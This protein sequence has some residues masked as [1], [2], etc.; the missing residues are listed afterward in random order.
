MKEL[1]IILLL[2]L[3]IYLSFI[4]TKP[5]HHKK[6]HKKHHIPKHAVMP[7]CW[8]DKV[9]P[10]H[11]NDTNNTNTEKYSEFNIQPQ[12]GLIDNSVEGITTSDQYNKIQKIKS[13]SEQNLKD[14][15]SVKGQL[16]NVDDKISNLNNQIT[17]LRLIR[18][19]QVENLEKLKQ[20]YNS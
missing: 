18:A 15:N 6:H 7:H 20:Y 11:F 17:D 16:K 9:N 1:I 14:I 4:N 10:C 12:P 13:D 5:K 2:I 19:K 8:F 3:V